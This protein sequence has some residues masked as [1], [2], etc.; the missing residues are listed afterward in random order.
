MKTKLLRYSL[1]KL[2]QVV[3]HYAELEKVS[4]GVY[5]YLKSKDQYREQ[6]DLMGIVL[7]LENVFFEYGSYPRQFL[8]SQNVADAGVKTLANFHSTIEQ[9]MQEGKHLQI[10]YV[11]IYEEMGRDT[12][13]LIRYREERRLRLQRENEEKKRCR[14][15]QQRQAEEREQERL[16][17]VGE[18]FD[19]GEF[20][21]CEDFIELSKQLQVPIPLRTH[22]TL[23][24]SVKEISLKS[25][26]YT[27]ERGKSKPK[28]DGC[29]ALVKALHSKLTAK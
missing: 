1:S 3:W 27:R 26:S 2:N 17:K 20:I 29:F 23:R 18:R 6:A 25:I 21:P 16:I 7:Q 13:P 22:G 19:A 4:N 14:E 15:E 11:R 5:T 24:R 10:L 28:L 9:T 12:A 8:A